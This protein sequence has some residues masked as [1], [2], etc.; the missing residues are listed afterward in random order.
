MKRVALFV[1]FLLWAGAVG[2]ADSEGFQ[3]RFEQERT[4]PGLDRPFRSEGR[5]I[6]VPDERLEWRTESPFEYRYILLPDRII[7]STPE[8]GEQTISLDEAPW[9]VSLNDLLTAVISGDE[10]AIAER[11]SVREA[12]EQPDNDLRRLVLVPEDARMKERIP[13]IRVDRDE[14]PR[15]IV[16]HESGGGRLEIRLHDFQGEVPAPDAA[17]EPDCGADEGS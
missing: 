12:D 8:D 10:A 1:T 14:Y 15:R 11:F 13:E 4:T 9:L 6:W 3:A 5:L 16:I 17:V 7:E 2:A